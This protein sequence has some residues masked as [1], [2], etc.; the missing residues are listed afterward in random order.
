MADH[1]IRLGGQFPRS[2]FDPC[3]PD[4]EVIATP[5][6]H[7]L[8]WWLRDQLTGAPQYLRET[9]E[10]LNAYL[11]DNC[12]HHWRESRECCVP[13]KDDCWPPH[14]QCLWCKT[15]EDLKLDQTPAREPHPTPADLAAALALLHNEP[16]ANSVN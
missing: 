5:V 4:G 6:E 10:V 9:F 12:Q 8:L 13:P 15:V 11:K 16:D 2:V 14:R 3:G 7:R 1:V